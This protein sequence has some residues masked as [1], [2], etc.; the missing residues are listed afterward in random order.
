MNGFDHEDNF[1]LWYENT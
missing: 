1:L